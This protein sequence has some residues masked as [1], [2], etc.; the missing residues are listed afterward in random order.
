MRYLGKPEFVMNS[1][2]RSMKTPKLWKE[3]KHDK[4]IQRKKGFKPT[5]YRKMTK[6]F[7]RIGYPSS[8]HQ[9]H[10]GINQLI[11]DSRR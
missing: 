10:E 5:P 4:L 8:I 6:G 9:A 2:N 1:I 11:L 7:Q 3:K